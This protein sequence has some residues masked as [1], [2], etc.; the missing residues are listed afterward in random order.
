MKYKKFIFFFVF[1]KVIVM[2]FVIVVICNELVLNE[3]EKEFYVVIILFVVY[4][5]GVFIIFG[6]I[7]FVYSGLECVNCKEVR[8]FKIKLILVYMFGICYFFYCGLYIWK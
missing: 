5:L 1:F 2:L 6:I 8:F 4:F 3:I 7:Y